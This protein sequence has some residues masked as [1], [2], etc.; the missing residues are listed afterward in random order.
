MDK[1]EN[2]RY[3]I[4]QLFNNHSKSLQIQSNKG[5]VEIEMDYKLTDKFREYA[6]NPYY[7]RTE[8]NLSDDRSY[9]WTFKELLQ[10]KR[11]LKINSK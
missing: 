4:K 1:K 3:L 6:G 10:I 11:F 2:I 7:F 9:L 5:K 8:I